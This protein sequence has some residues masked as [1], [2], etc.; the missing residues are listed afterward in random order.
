MA[1]TP[2][3]APDACRVE[4]FSNGHGIFGQCLGLGLHDQLTGKYSTVNGRATADP[5]R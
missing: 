5:G 2:R 4:P 3:A 1:S